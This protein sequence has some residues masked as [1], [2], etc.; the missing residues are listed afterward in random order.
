MC[1]GRAASSQLVQTF[2]TCTARYELVDG[3]RHARSTDAALNTHQAVIGID[4]SHARMGLA[5]SWEQGSVIRVAPTSSFHECTSRL[6]FACPAVHLSGAPM[7]SEDRPT[8]PGSQT[9]QRSRTAAPYAPCTTVVAA[10]DVPISQLRTRIA[11]CQ[12]ACVLSSLLLPLSR[13]CSQLRA[14][15]VGCSSG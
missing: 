3:S 11:S 14:A 13:R 4:H 1:I 12:L 2:R 9:K 7:F 10:F 5:P 6:A 8:T 15:L